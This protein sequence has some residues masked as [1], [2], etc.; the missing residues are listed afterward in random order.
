[1]P[2]RAL[3]FSLALH[4]AFLVMVWGWLSRIAHHAGPGDPEAGVTFSAARGGGFLVEIPAA[5]PAEA[6]VTPPSP[7]PE[8]TPP[9]QAV[10][11]PLPAVAELTS[12]IPAARSL[13]T[14]VPAKM[15]A[16]T[17]GRTARRG[18]HAAGATTGPARGSGNGR[19]STGLA[20]SGPGSG[21]GGPGFVPPQFRLRYKPPYPEKARTHQLEGTVL[22]LVSLDARGRVTA[23][24]LQQTCGHEILDQAAIK[25]VRSW[26]FEPARQNGTTLAAQVVVPIRFKFEQRTSNRA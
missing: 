16:A 8:F 21:G 17:S 24:A 18:S 1:M 3:L 26:L 13:P 22:L 9:S 25:A 4:A 15:S 6:A 2:R 23:V 14:A 19:E 12:E 5:T 10:E 20:G 11:I 7:E